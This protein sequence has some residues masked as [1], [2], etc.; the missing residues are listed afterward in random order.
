MFKN[1]NKNNALN[2]YSSIPFQILKTFLTEM[3]ET[4]LVKETKEAYT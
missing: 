1:L 4:Q 2:Y 3:I